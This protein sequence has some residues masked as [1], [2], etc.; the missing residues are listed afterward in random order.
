MRIDKNGRLG[1][2]VSIL[3][4]CVV[5][6]VVALSVG[7]VLRGGTQTA[8]Q[9]LNA[10]DE[11]YVV[12]VVERVRDFSVNAVDVGDIFFERNAALL[13]EVVDT[14]TER[15]NEI[16]IMDDGTLVGMDNEFR[17]NLFV[18][19][20]AQGFVS[21]DEGYFIGGNNHVSAGQLLQVQSNRLFVNMFV[22]EV[23]S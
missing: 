10:N 23:H 3:D 21:A 7:F 8:A 15:F 4:V 17:Y 16:V 9:I 6:L 12:L 13:G 19:L 2:R 22:H 5:V 1:G 20:R 18:R 14:W 11:F